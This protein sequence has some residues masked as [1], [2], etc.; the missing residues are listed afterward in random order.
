MSEMD[1]SWIPLLVALVAGLS[2]V[3]VQLWINRGE[4]AAIK[5]I[6]LLN[7]AIAGMP[8]GDAGKLKLTE[9]RT[10][11]AVLVGTR[12][13]G[14]RGVPRLLRKAGWWSFLIGA[15]LIASWIVRVLLDPRT[16]TASGVERS[17]IVGTVLLVLALSFLIYSVVWPATETAV[18]W[19]LRSLTKLF[20][21]IRAKRDRKPADRTRGDPNEP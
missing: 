3:G 19:Y 4:P 7:E 20:E 16:A 14:L 1:S 13:I 15:V 17:L 8:E 18:N 12:L 21:W 10:H 2:T 11:L 9:A 5:R 6:K